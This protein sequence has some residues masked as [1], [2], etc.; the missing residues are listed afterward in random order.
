MKV[1]KTKDAQDTMPLPNSI[2]V[3]RM[4]FRFPSSID[5]VIVKDYPEESFLYIG[6][7]LLL[8]HLEPYLIRSMREAKKNIQ[9]AGLVLDLDAFIGQ[10]GQH[11]RQHA[12]FNKSLL[13]EQRE[14]LSRLE[15]ALA[16]DYERFSRTRSLR[17]NLAYAEGFE[18]LTAALTVFALHF[19]YVDKI[20]PGVRDLFRWHMVEELEHRTV[21]FDV[22]QHVC[23]SYVYRVLIG[24]FAQWHFLRFV[25]RVV[26]I[27]KHSRYGGRLETLARVSPLIGRALYYLV[28]K[29][30]GSYAPWY[31]P[32]KLLIPAIVQSACEEY[33]ERARSRSDAS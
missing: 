24:L 27:L 18:A 31:N 8:P 17:F 19:K 7:S 29:V 32:R 33:T 22:Y 4:P 12:A 3:R 9:D 26:G 11:Y 2:T 20:D 15:A 28:P 13:L 1:M 16:D 10:E 5:P 25:L 6:L 14:E 30:L 21:A 23:G